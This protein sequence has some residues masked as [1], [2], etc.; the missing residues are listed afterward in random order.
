VKK[1]KPAVQLAQEL[2]AKKWGILD[3]EKEMESLTLRQYLDI[4]RKPL[5]Q[6]AMEAIRKLTEV[7]ELKKKK[8]RMAAKKKKT[9]PSVKEGVKKV[10]GKAT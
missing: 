9:K 1:R 10:A 6:T 7:A 3:V 2:L 8:N 4:Y 5:S